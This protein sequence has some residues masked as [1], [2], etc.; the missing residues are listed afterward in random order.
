MSSNKSIFIAM[1]FCTLFADSYSVRDKT[2]RKLSKKVVLDR[3][4]ICNCPF[5]YLLHNNKMNATHSSS[6]SSVSNNRQKIPKQNCLYHQNF[7]TEEIP[8]AQTQT[9]AES[10]KATAITE[11][12]ARTDFFVALTTA[13]NSQLSSLGTTAA[14]V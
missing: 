14:T 8:A 11:A 6:S 2:F 3:G 1:M 13:P 12:T 4:M 9:S 10:M 7:V 5:L